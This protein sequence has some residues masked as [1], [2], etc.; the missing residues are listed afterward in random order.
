MG[1]LYGKRDPDQTILIACRCG[2]DSD[3]NPSSSAGVLFTTM[4]FRKLPVRFNTGLDEQREFSHTAY[5]FP[6][7]LD[8]CDKLTRQFLI[9]QGGRVEHDGNGEECFVIP[10]KEPVSSKLELSW[11]PGPIAN[12]RFTP[13][14]MAQDQ[15]RQHAPRNQG[16]GDGVRT[17]WQIKDCGP[18]MNPGLRTEWQGRQ[19]VLCVH[20]LDA[21][22]GCVLART[23]AVPAGKKTTLRMVVGHDPQGDFD[24]IVRA[25]GKELLR[26]PVSPATCAEGHWLKQDVDLTTFAGHE[27]KLELVNQPTGWSNEAAYWAEIAIVSE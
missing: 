27:V 11:A 17:G 14:E 18:D 15:V 13:D 21:Q 8:V 5:N 7:L 12:S 20:P 3:C 19:K 6:R 23:V 2:M 1:L 24:L 25:D 26:K 10:V 22:T 16:G 9:L 4:G